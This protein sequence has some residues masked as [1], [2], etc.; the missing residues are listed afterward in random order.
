MKDERFEQVSELLALITIH[1]ASSIDSRE[2]ASALLNEVIKARPSEE[3]GQA[4]ERGT[5]K[6]LEE[7][8]KEILEEGS[9]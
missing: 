5:A 9:S 6:T 7:L 4:Y 8:I 2:K 3:I 1:P